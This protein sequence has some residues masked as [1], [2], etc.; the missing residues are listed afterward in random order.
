M[1][2]P[3]C[4]INKMRLQK[5]ASNQHLVLRVAYTLTDAVTFLPSGRTK[6]VTETP[7]K[8]PKMV[9]ARVGEHEP[10]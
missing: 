7:K 1:T 8:G 10:P 9:F 6:L 4:Q 3:D 5:V 2:D